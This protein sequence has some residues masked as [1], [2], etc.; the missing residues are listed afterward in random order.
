[1]LAT[2]CGKI[3]IYYDYGFDDPD[4]GDCYCYIIIIIHIYIEIMVCLGNSVRVLHDRMPDARAENYLNN[5]K[6][7]N[8]QRNERTK[9]TE[10]NGVA[11]MEPNNTMT[12][13]QT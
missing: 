5:K 3:Y 1:M 11:T 10:R 7:E 8:N 4:R 13:R 9:K 12:Y 2:R 6:M